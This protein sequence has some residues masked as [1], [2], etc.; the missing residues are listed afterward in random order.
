MSKS[1]ARHMVLCGFGT[2]LVVILVLAGLRTYRS[3]NRPTTTAIVSSSG[4]PLNNFFDGLKPDPRYSL[5]RI[6]SLKRPAC[7]EKN[8]SSLLRFPD[9]ATVHAQDKCPQTECNGQG[10]DTIRAS[11]NTGGPCNGSYLDVEPDP[12]SQEGYILPG[13]YCQTE[14]ECGCEAVTCSY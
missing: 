2:V 14:P 12:D 9:I 11:C 1:S 5:E 10:W 4:Q 7:G 8:A 13:T 6:R 3:N